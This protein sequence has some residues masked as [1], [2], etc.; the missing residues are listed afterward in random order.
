MYSSPVRDLHFL[1]LFLT[2]CCSSGSWEADPEM[3]LSFQEVY[4]GI[5]LGSTPMGKGKKAG[6]GRGRRL[7]AMQTQQTPCQPHGEL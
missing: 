7:A 4:W 5:P 1:L 3:E 6:L 2:H